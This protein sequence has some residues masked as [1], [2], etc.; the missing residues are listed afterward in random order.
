MEIRQEDVENAFDLILEA[1]ELMPQIFTEMSSGSHDDN[2]Q[3]AWT[4]IFQEHLRTGKGVP[5]SRLNYFLQKRVPAQM[6]SFTIDAMFTSKMIMA[7][8]TGASP[9]ARLLRP[10]DLYKD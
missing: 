7:E 9:G 10:L 1:E 3:E 2:I 6:I 5:E 8:D 4:Y